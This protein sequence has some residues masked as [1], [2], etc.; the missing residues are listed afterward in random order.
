M[1]PATARES[2]TRAVRDAPM[3][4]TVRYPNG[5]IKY[6][7]FLLHGEM[8]GAWRWYRLDGSL[9]RSGQFDRG[10]QVGVWHTCNRAGTIVKET[11]F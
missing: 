10:R 11:T 8:H 2:H 4:E 9:M 1:A 5:G 6:T 3:V 7:G